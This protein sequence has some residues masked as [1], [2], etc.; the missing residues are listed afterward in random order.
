MISRISNNIL[1]TEI[2]ATEK[3]VKIVNFIV[4]MIVL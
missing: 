2:A 3:N 4:S 1:L